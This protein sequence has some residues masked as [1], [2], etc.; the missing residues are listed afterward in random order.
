MLLAP[1]SSTNPRESER[2]VGVG[3]ER[4]REHACMRVCVCFT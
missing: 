2:L 1:P 3:G 4:E